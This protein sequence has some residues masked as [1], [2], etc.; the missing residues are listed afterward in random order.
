MTIH[1]YFF[2]QFSFM[3]YTIILPNFNDSGFSKVSFHKLSKNNDKYVESN[4]PKNLPI[5]L[6]PESII[7]TINMVWFMVFNTTFN[8]I[9]AIS[10]RPVL[11]VEETGVPGKNH[12]PAACHWMLYWVHLAWVGFDLITLVVIGTDCIGSYKSNYHTITT[13]T[14]TTPPLQSVIESSI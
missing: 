3:I 9:S 5:Q 2:Y 1:P 14:M 12:Q 11:L 10:R 7:H 8:N 4:V 13:T 6:A